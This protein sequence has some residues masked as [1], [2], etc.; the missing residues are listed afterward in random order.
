MKTN[1]ISR[2]CFFF[3]VCL[4]IFSFGKVYAS[5]V[6]KI[7]MYENSSVMNATIVRSTVSKLSDGVTYEIFMFTNQNGRIGK[8]DIAILSNEKNMDVQS[9][10]QKTFRQSIVTAV[11]DIRSCITVNKSDEEILQCIKPWV[12]KQ[13]EGVTVD[14]IMNLFEQHMDEVK[15]CIQ[16]QSE[17]SACVA[18]ILFP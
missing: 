5:P 2:L 17:D 4:F 10:I 7:K 16:S 6:V 18:D 13:F 12:E 1:I 3:T 8:I 11:P 15:E 9:L 14:L